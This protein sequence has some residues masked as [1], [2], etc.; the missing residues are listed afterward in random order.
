VLAYSGNI[1]VLQ[2]HAMQQTMVWYWFPLSDNWLRLTRQHILRGWANSSKT[3]WTT[4]FLTVAWT[5]SSNL[6]QSW[7]KSGNRTKKFLRGWV[8]IR[9]RGTLKSNSSSEEI[10][11][12]IRE[13]SIKK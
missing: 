9:A 2:T 7:N 11:P 4:Q 5:S 1:W 3:W 13:I 6:L 10:K 12:V 8:E